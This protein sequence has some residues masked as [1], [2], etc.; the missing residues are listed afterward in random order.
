MLASK[1]ECDALRV[2]S[3]RVWETRQYLAAIDS[4]R[5]SDRIDRLVC[6]GTEWDK[7]GVRQNRQ[8]GGEPLINCLRSKGV[9]RGAGAPL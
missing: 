5:L 8:L 4:C 7:H 6:Y 1:E 2:G 3:A 9:G